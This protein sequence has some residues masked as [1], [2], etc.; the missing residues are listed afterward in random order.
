MT[1]RGTARRDCV[2]AWPYRVPA[3]IAVRCP[4]PQPDRAVRSRGPAILSS[5]GQCPHV[6][7]QDVVVMGQQVGEH[8]IQVPAVHGVRHRLQAQ[9]QVDRRSMSSFGMLN[10]PRIPLSGD[11]RH[12]AN[13]LTSRAAYRPTPTPTPTPSQRPGRATHRTP[14]LHVISTRIR[15][16]QLTRASAARVIDDHCSLYPRAGRLVLA[17]DAL[18]VHTLNSTRTLC[19][20]DRSARTPALSVAASTERDC[21]EEASP[22][23]GSTDNRSHVVAP[24]TW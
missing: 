7:W 24:S 10:A 15:W 16:R 5:P 6:L 14:F 20:R 23:R 18:G 22:G 17:V 11:C 13:G 9:L 19:R 1:A 2:T 4:E 21:Y 12:I 8:V 3:A